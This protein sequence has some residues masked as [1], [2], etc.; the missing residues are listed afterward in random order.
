MAINGD[1]IPPMVSPIGPVSLKLRIDIGLQVN[2][3]G[4]KRIATVKLTKIIFFFLNF[5][6]DFSIFLLLK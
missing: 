1:M 6:S 2:N 3:N 5:F 4:K